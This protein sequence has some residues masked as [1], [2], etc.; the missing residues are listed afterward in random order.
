VEVYGTALGAH[1]GA[2]GA[3]VGACAD[4]DLAAGPVTADGG[5]AEVGPGGSYG[6]ID[7]SDANTGHAAGYAGFNNGGISEQ[8]E[9]DAD[10]DGNDDDQTALGP[11]PHAGGPAGAPHD[12]PD[13]NS[14]G[15][16]W[17]RTGA[18]DPVDGNKTNDVTT[19]FICGNTS[20][21]DWQSSKRD[22]CSVP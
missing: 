18:G 4:T 17:V 1:G 2:G 20:G 8:G 13:N 14:G 5:Y 9:R 3:A 10:C 15:C 19:L 16:F 21:P 11:P 6:V 7:G 22:G 12:G